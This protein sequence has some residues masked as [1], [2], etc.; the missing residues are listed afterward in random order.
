[1][2]AKGT[3]TTKKVGKEKEETNITVEVSKNNQTNN[4]SSA[5]INALLSLVKQMQEEIK[6]NIEDFDFVEDTDNATKELNKILFYDY[7][8]NWQNYIEFEI[9]EKEIF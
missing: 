1:M 9:I 6:H 3:T 5:E 4:E 2:P 7:Q 8:E